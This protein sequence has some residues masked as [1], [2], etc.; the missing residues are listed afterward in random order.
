[1]ANSRL[2]SAE[3]DL[4]E[5]F[6][7][8]THAVGLVLS[9]VAAPLLVLRALETANQGAFLGALIFGLSLVLLYGAST[10]YHFVEHPRAKAWMQFVDHACIFLLIAGSY[11]PFALVVLP[12]PWADGF[13]IAAWSIAVV[14]V[15]FKAFFVGRF[16]MLSNILY[17]GMGWMAVIGWEPLRASLPEGGLTWVLL[18]GAFYTLGIAFYVFDRRVRY[19]H[20][21]WHLFVLAGSAAHF[22]AVYR[23]VLPSA[24]AA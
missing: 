8:G 24:A 7:S 9:V 2:P 4:E 6:N 21:V 3:R 12:Q 22:V 17:L 18:G 23:Y 20:A 10:A 16:T 11:T 15:G 14:G 5:W 13:L 1:M 19:F